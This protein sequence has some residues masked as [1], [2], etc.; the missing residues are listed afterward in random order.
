VSY[1]GGLFSQRSSG[2]LRFAPD[3]SG[4]LRIGPVYSGL[5]WWLPDQ[6]GVGFVGQLW[7]APDC[8][9]SPKL[10]GRN[11]PGSSDHAKGRKG[12]KKGRKVNHGF[13]RMGMI[14]GRKT[15]SFRCNYSQLLATGASSVAKARE[16]RGWGILDP[17]D[18]STSPPPH[19]AERS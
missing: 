5:G 17:W 18:P 7:F 4:L 19:F 12:R 16:N 14:R 3:W 10:Q 9:G 8:F 11:R 1:R 2:L 6:T 15:E 13:A